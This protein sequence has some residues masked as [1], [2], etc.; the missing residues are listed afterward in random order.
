MDV[1]RKV[2]IALSGRNGG[3][4]A[5]APAFRTPGAGPRQIDV[6]SSGPQAASWIGRPGWRAGD[7]RSDIFAAEP[8]AERNARLEEL[9]AALAASPAVAPVAGTAAARAAP[10]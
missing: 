7:V 2:G 10:P 1:L 8:K 9:A 6:G 3:G 4:R 5:G